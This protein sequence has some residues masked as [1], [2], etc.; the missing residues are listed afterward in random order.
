MIK[1]VCV[2]CGSSN[3]ASDYFKS[4]AA[5]L[6]KYLAENNWNLVYGGSSVGLMG[7]VADAVLENGGKA[8]GIIPK[9]LQDREV[10][11]TGLTEFY[12]VETM[13]ERK[14]MMVDKSDAFVTLPGGLGTMD[15]MFELLTWKQ[16]GLHDKP[17]ILANLESYWDH[18]E[19][20]V[21]NIAKEKFMNDK[22][23]EL[24]TTV[25]QIED[26]PTALKNSKNETF[27][28]TTKWI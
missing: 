25:T 20:L 3:F 1:S 23:L 2:Y 28:P 11:H 6:G 8:I 26:V 5:L 19:G 12:E 27:D 4:Q 24:F 14:Q 15:E 13:H 17:I 7:I 21:Q 16:L 10:E 18:F 22:H 9:F